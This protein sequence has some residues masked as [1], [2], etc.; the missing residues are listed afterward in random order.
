MFKVY[1][2]AQWDMP[3]TWKVATIV[4]LHKKGPRYDPNNYRPISVLPVVS[5]LCERVVC[6]QLMAYL[7]D[8]HLLCPQQYGF[9]P[10]MSTEASLLDAVTYTVKNIDRGLVMS[11]VSCHCR[12]FQC[13]WQRWA[14]PSSGQARLVRDRRPVVRCLAERSNTD[15]ELCCWLAKCDPRHCPGL[16]FRANFVYHFYVRP[17]TARA[18]LQSWVVCWWLPVFFTLNLL[19]SK[20]WNV[21]SK[22]TSQ[23]F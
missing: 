16:D 10:G 6:T 14:R 20:R 15:C 17:A 18:E 23:Q 11:L 13:L 4:P 1:A 3:R 19:R 22:I 2:Y 9:R 8:H 21:V 5:K 7:S 12:H